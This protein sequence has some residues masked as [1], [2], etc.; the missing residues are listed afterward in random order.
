MNNF[1][2][3]KTFKVAFLGALS[4]VTYFNHTTP[5]RAIELNGVKYCTLS[6]Q[7]SQDTII[8]LLVPQQSV[9][10]LKQQLDVV[11]V[12]CST[13]PPPQPLF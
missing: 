10:F 11:H 7:Q 1:F 2:S 4:I 5:A 12:D 6:V 13:S 8:D 9:V 3:A